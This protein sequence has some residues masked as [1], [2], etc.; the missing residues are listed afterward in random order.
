MGPWVSYGCCL[1]VVLIRSK[2]S[3]YTLSGGHWCQAICRGHCKCWVILL[4]CSPRARILENTDGVTLYKNAFS[5]ACILVVWTLEAMETVNFILKRENYFPKY[6]YV[7][8]SI[9]VYL[10]NI[11]LYMDTFS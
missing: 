6:S 7:W 9:Y 4:T 3:N 8:Q 2:V 1:W 5:W 10:N 11:A